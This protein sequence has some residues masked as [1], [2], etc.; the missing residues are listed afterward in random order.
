MNEGHPMQRGTDQPQHG[1]LD[2]NVPDASEE[3]DSTR[4]EMGRVR[5]RVAAH[6]ADYI[7]DQQAEQ[8][9]REASKQVRPPRGNRLWRVGE[10]VG[11][12]RDFP[13]CTGRASTEG[14][15]EAEDHSIEY[16]PRPRFSARVAWRSE[17]CLAATTGCRAS[18]RVG[19][20]AQ[21]DGV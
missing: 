12:V 17:R 19:P 10:E 7:H 1:F 4:R 6:A 9:P 11:H 13:G 20:A 14:L 3:R 16:S 15:F 21:E 18:S 2:P 5:A 8:T